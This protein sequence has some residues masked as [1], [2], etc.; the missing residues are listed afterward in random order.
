MQFVQLLEDT[1]LNDTKHHAAL[2]P[3]SNFLLIEFMMCGMNHLALL[4]I[5]NL[6][7]YLKSNCVM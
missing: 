2:T 1:R 7:L 3:R 6:L 4:S 5:P